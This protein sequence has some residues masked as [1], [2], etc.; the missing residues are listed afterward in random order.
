MFL[1]EFRRI[2]E[3]MMKKLMLAVAVVLSVSIPVVHADATSQKAIIE[4]ILIVTKADANVDQT[5]QALYTQLRTMMEKQFAEMGASDDLSPILKRYLDKVFNIMEQ[6]MSWKVLKNDMIDLYEQ[7][8]TEDE[9]NGMLAFYKSPVGQSVV[10]KMPKVMQQS[11]A[12]AQKY[13]P[14][15]QRKIVKISEEFEE[16]LKA[17]KAK[18]KDDAGR[19]P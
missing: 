2:P 17:V 8:F 12:I 4:E 16:E 6:T 19:K 9:L 5:I 1:V 7:T 14:E 11:I 18:K 3:V 10:D 13:M 15:M